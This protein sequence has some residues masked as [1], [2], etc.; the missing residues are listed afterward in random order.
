MS[1]SWTDELAAGGEARA[2]AL[3][4]SKALDRVWH[5]RLLHKLEELVSPPSH[6]ALQLPV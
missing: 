5:A 6:M 1:Q 4:I 3:D 2:V